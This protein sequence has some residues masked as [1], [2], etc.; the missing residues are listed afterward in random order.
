MIVAQVVYM[1]TNTLLKFS[2]VVIEG[3]VL[4]VTPK[5]DQDKKLIYSYVDV[6]ITRVFKGEIKTDVITLKEMG[7]SID[8]CTT[9]SS[10][11]PVYQPDESV[12]LFLKQNNTTGEYYTNGYWLGKFVIKEKNNIKKLVRNMRELIIMD[13]NDSTESEIEYGNFQKKLKISY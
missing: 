13:K 7:G 8:N 6:S 10:I 4:K 5:W 3:K 1:T 9:L 2:H 12:I 11:H